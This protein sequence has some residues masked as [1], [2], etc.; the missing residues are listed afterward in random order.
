MEQTKDMDLLQ[1]EIDKINLLA[2]L[3]EDGDETD[4][5]LENLPEKIAQQGREMTALRLRPKTAPADW[6]PRAPYGRPDDDEEKPKPKSK[7]PKPKPAQK[8]S[9]AKKR[10]KPAPRTGGRQSLQRTAMEWSM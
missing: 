1:T 3:E 6:E 7:P 10:A 2:S 5:E 4:E 9:P 8:P